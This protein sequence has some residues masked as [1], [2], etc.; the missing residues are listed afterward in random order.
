LRARGKALGA[1]RNEI[2]TW[3]GE[4]I[5]AVYHSASSGRSAGAEEVWRQAL[6]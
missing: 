4:P 6:P 1:T 3:R 2:L 5:L